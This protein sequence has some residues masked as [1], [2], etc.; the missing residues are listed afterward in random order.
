MQ[1]LLKTGPVFPAWSG[2]KSIMGMQSEQGSVSFAGKSDSEPVNH[3][4]HLNIYDLYQGAVCVACRCRL[5]A[6]S[7]FQV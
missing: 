1:T 5:A 7:S 2:V 4:N 3:L 6:S